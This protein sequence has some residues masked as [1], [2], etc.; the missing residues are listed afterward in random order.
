MYVQQGGELYGFCPAKATWDPWTVNMYRALMVAVTTGSQWE[1]GGLGNQPEW[2][3]DLL[4]WFATRYDIT[5]FH[6]KAVM[7]L[8]DGKDAKTQG[9][10]KHGNQQRTTNRRSRT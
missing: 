2:W 7:V 1:D 3:I 4:S 5:N 6:R 8:G 9:V 10:S